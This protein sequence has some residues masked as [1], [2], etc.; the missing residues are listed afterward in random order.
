MGSTA[1][2]P[3]DNYYS[4]SGRLSSFYDSGSDLCFVQ[5]YKMYACSSAGDVVIRMSP[6]LGSD[7][8]GHTFE[9]VIESQRS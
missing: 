4:K 2:T 8:F 5:L 3:I 6:N 1:P 7:S 9:T